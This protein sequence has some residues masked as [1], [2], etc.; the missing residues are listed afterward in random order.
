MKHIPLMRLRIKTRLRLLFP[1]LRLV[2]L[3]MALAD[4][5]GLLDNQNLGFSHKEHRLTAGPDTQYSLGS[6]GMSVSAVLLA[7]LHD[8]GMLHLDDPV[9]AHIPEFRVMDEQATRTLSIRDFLCHQSGFRDSEFMYG[10]RQ[11]GQR[12]I[13]DF[14]AE[15]EPFCPPRTEYGFCMLG[16]ALV[17]LVAERA[18]GMDFATLAQTRLFEPLGM[19]RTGY[20]VP[21]GEDA[22]TGYVTLP[23]GTRETHP[24]EPM[25]LNASCGLVSTAGDMAKWL[26]FCLRD[27]APLLKDGTMQ[28]LQTPLLSVTRR[29]HL[30]KAVSVR[31]ACGWR[32]EDYQGWHLLTCAGGTEGFAASL[33][34]IPSV[35]L[36]L[37][38]LSNSSGAGRLAPLN[39]ILT[40]RLMGL[41]KTDWL[42]VFR[43]YWHAL[44]APQ[45]ELR[46]EIRRRLQAPEPLPGRPDAYP[47]VYRHASGA[48]AELAFVSDTY[49]LRLGGAVHRF[50]PV[51]GP[52]FVLTCAF[53]VQYGVKFNARMIP[54]KHGV[55]Q[56]LQLW[57]DSAVANPMDFH[58][59]V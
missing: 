14:F 31:S 6:A 44:M 16:Y 54:D 52:D 58:R 13:L 45:R 12:E 48:E 19:L 42:S 9:I 59:V 27:G 34:V 38:L 57:L 53:A 15:A 32:V 23:D 10:G 36:G 1:R 22:A 50:E 8:E 11:I 20:G 47:G 39:Y 25:G 18:S 51:G 43:H 33:A 2:G 30:H 17:G 3:S 29:E 37:V 46:A 24:A 41:E 56:Q 7:L 55:P 5:D 4:R 40:D 49:T 28:I 21:S 35:G 26:A